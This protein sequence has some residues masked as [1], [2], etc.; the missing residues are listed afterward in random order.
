MLIN[1]LFI[2]VIDATLK[3][4]LTNENS[5]LLEDERLS[6]P[7]VEKAEPVGKA[8]VSE[9][10]ASTLKLAPQ[11]LL[12]LSNWLSLSKEIRERILR[13]KEG[14]VRGRVGERGVG[15]GE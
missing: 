5:L 14:K 13:E 10:I 3:G 9:S 2:C 8:K 12:G 15:D 1:H 6:K 11:D 7:E 4:R